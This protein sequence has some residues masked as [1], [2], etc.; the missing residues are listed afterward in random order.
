MMRH[1]GLDLPGGSGVKNPPASAGTRGPSLV[2]GVPQAAEQLS[3]CPT[4]AELA[5]SNH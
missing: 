3:L 1:A 4:T 2:Q 5:S